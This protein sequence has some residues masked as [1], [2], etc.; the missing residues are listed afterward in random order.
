MTIHAINSVKKHWL[1]ISIIF[2]SVITVLSLAPLK[3]LSNSPGSDKTNHLIAYAA[4][5]YPASLRRP[6]GWRY[7]ILFFT[8]YSGLIE[9]IQPYMNRHSDWIDFVANIIGLALGLILALLTDKL[10][11]NLNDQLKR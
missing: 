1:P 7:T 5:A 11:D 9:I 10:Q 6:A 3:E 4:L 2:V 8:L